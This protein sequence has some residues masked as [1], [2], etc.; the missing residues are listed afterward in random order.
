MSSSAN[1]TVLSGNGCVIHVV[2]SDTER[3]TRGTTAAGGAPRLCLRLGL[4]FSAAAA[5]PLLN[6]Y[7]A[8]LYLKESAR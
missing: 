2:N 5:M 3:S 7:T 1:I 8:L 4:L 6:L